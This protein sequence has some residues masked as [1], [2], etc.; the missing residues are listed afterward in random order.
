MPDDHISALERLARL[1]DSGVLSN[2]E[3][4]LEKARILAGGS[5]GNGEAANPPVYR[6]LWLVVTMTAL[7]LT[8]PL[9]L[10]VLVT[11]QVYRRRDGEWQAISGTARTVYAGALGLWLISAGIYGALH[12]NT[13]RENAVNTGQ[14]AANPGN[15]AEDGQPI[16][17]DS[18]DAV[19]MVKSA[20]ENNATARLVQVKILDFGKARQVYADRS[21]KVRY[22]VAEAELNTGG[23]QVSYKLYFGPSGAQMVEVRQGDDPFGAE[24][25]ASRERSAQAQAQSAASGGQGGTG[26]G[27]P[28]NGPGGSQTASGGQSVAGGECTPN[29]PQGSR[30][31]ATRPTLLAEGYRPAAPNP[32]ED[33]SYCSNEDNAQICRVVPETEDCS[34]DG[35]CKMTFR[36]AD[37]RKL[38]ITTFGD[39]PDDA[40][41]RIQG[42]S[43]SCQ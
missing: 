34:A 2:Q 32:P 42:V 25:M 40:N 31:W 35:H 10:L 17:C 15:Q 33:G 19:D 3:F 12:P 37:G 28:E 4:D 23:H 14:V 26:N 5:K 29:I 7:L 30:Y 21:N 9:A 11:G 13:Y 22:C 36:G 27:G 39:G 43:G 41:V 38:E 16:S 24:G 8:F 18:S 6:R 20:V 1:R